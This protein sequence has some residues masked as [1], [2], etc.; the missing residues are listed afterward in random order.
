M[1]W[2]RWTSV[3][4]PSYLGEFSGSSSILFATFFWDTLHITLEEKEDVGRPRGGVE[5]WAGHLVFGLG[6][7]QWEHL[8]AH[9]PGWS[10]LPGEGRVRIFTAAISLGLPGSCILSAIL[11]HQCWCWHIRCLSLFT[12]LNTFCFVHSGPW[13]TLSSNNHLK[14]PTPP[15]IKAFKLPVIT[16]YVL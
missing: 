7:H 8:H 4:Q 16:S 11:N 14:I 5:C 2:S 12:S 9:R 10:R 13:S 15:Q 6:A 1:K 3:Q